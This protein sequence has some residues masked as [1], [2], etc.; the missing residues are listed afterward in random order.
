MLN[1][2]NNLYD[3]KFLFIFYDVFIA[4]PGTKFFYFCFSVNSGRMGC[5]STPRSIISMGA[6]APLYIYI[7]IYYVFMIH[8]YNINIIY[9]LCNQRIAPMNNGWL[10]ETSFLT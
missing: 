2:T 1:Q 8:I 5:D 10:I 3:S 9:I 7:Y 4:Y 6:W